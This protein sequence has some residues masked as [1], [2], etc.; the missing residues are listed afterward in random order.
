MN[1]TIKREELL[2]KLWLGGM[3]AEDIAGYF[4]SMGYL[5]VIRNTIL[6]RLR[7]MRKK[8]RLHDR[9][10]THPSTQGTNRDTIWTPE[11][12]ELAK[13]LWM[14]GLSGEVI[15]KHFQAKAQS[16]VLEERLLGIPDLTRSAV[17]GR[18][19]RMREAGEL[20]DSARKKPQSAARNNSKRR[21]SRPKAKKPQLA[22]EIILETFVP[23]QVQKTVLVLT[24]PKFKNFSFFGMPETGACR[25]VVAGSGASALY[26]GNA[27]SGKRDQYCAYHAGLLHRPLPLEESKNL[28]R[29]QANSS[30][31]NG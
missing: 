5:T 4:R 26:C 9:G 20:D 15:A 27:T 30:Y 31:I 1:W 14:Q 21:R 28:T 3:S 24:K 18:I 8:G 6:G 10:R 2:V 13:T 29:W 12:S 7:T 25:T 17:I 11:H 22:P 16:A 19:N 23:A